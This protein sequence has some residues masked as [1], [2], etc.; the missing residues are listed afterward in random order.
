MK[1]Y[2]KES[3]GDI[4]TEVLISR[5]SIQESGIKILSLKQMLQRLPIA[6]TQ[7]P[8]CNT[9]KKLL[10]KTQQI[11]HSLNQAKQILKK[12]YNNLIKSV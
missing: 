1:E 3:P 11:V 6:L 10:N 7:V 9:S 4:L 2:L 8:A 5:R 12:V